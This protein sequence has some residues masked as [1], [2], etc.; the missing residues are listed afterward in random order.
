VCKRFS[1]AETKMTGKTNR[2]KQE[3]SITKIRKRIVVVLLK[4]I[5]FLPFR[6]IYGLS[7]FLFF[8]N[9]FFLKYRYRVTTENLQFAFPEKTDE[10]RALIRDQF[11][12]YFFDF[13]L[14]SVKLYNASEQQLCKRIVFKN[15]PRYEKLTGAKKG[16]IVL[17]F[18]Y[19][20]WEWCSFIQTQFKYPILMVYNPPRY[21]RPMERFLKHSRGKWGGRVIPT[22]QAAR[23][24]FEYKAKGEPAVLWLAADQTAKANSPFWI[25]FLNRE[26]AFFTGPEKIA[27]KTNLPVFFQHVKKVARGKYEVE[28]SLL[29][30]EP[31]KMKPNEILSAYVEKMEEI[32]RQEPAYYLW[33]HRRWKH[34]RPNNTKLIK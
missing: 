14:E 34:S 22:A 10:E 30:E 19:N 15:L 18:H 9:K 33:S 3:G 23:A 32:I 11:Y 13:S 21:N 6:V 1:F 24:I 5:S 31:K 28:L 8:L 4:T 25:T 7:T 12:R 16:A 27:E 29:A 26:A 20:N 2:E 17:A